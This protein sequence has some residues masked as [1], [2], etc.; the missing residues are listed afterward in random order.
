MN[1][2][3]KGSEDTSEGT[4]VDTDRVTEA[5]LDAISSGDRTIEIK[6]AS[7][8]RG[9]GLTR[10]VVLAAGA[11]GLAYWVA[12]SRKPDELIETAKKETADRTKQVSEQAA[13]KIERGSERAGETVQNAGETAA[14]QTETAGKEAADAAEGGEKD[15]EAGSS[16]FSGG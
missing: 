14:E 12:N 11:V 8:S 4:N 5:V 2:Q 1:E 15:D 3:L 16:S 7:R 9:T 10:L 13:A 6:P